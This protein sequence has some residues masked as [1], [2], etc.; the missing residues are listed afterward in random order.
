MWNFI[1]SGG[2]LW[3]GFISALACIVLIGVE[4]GVEG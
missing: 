3:V 1:D 4:L 2:L